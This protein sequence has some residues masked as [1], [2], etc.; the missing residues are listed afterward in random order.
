MNGIPQIV[1]NNLLAGQLLDCLENNL[2][3]VTCLHA[4]IT[5]LYL[6]ANYVA[7]MP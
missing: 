6:C 5:V 1:M 7:I 2:N 3:H 4:R